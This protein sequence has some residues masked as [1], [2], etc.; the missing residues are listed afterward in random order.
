MPYQVIITNDSDCPE[1]NGNVVFG[2]ST[3]GEAQ[4]FLKGASYVN[5]SAL[6]LKLEAVD[7]TSKGKTTR[8]FFLDDFDTYAGGGFV[9]DVTDT[10]LD[11]IEGG[12]PIGHLDIDKSRFIP[13]DEVVGEVSVLI[14]NHK[15]GTDVIAYVDED[16]CHKGAL[17]IVREYRADFDVDEEVSDEDALTDWAEHTGNTEYLETTVCRV[18]HSLDYGKEA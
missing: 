13:A 4:G 8:L 9:I 14:Y 3:H 12:T 16:A 1:N 6:T 7:P 18:N 17:E 11:E 5:D 10:E 15:H 2:P